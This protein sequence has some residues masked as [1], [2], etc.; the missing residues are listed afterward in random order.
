MKTK[1]IFGACSIQFLLLLLV[2]PFST[3]TAQS[4]FNEVYVELSQG[5]WYS[6]REDSISNVPVMWNH[7][8]FINYVQLYHRILGAHRLSYPNRAVQ[9]SA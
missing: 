3:A 4:T 2:L 6:T 1:V 9:L 5:D 7:Q 8:W